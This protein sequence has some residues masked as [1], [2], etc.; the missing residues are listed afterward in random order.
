[1]AKKVLL[2]GADRIWYYMA[3]SLSERGFAIFHYGREFPE[4]LIGVKEIKGKEELWDLLNDEECIALP[5]DDQNGQYIYMESQYMDTLP[6]SDCV[7]DV[8][9]QCKCKC[10]WWYL[11]NDISAI[12]CK[13]RDTF[14]EAAIVEAKLLSGR[15][16]CGSGAVV[17]GFGVLAER[18]AR[19]LK[20]WECRVWVVPDD[21]MER[22]LAGYRQYEICEREQLLSYLDL[23]GSGEEKPDF[24]FQCSTNYRLGARQLCHM[25]Q[26][27]L[28]LNLTGNETMVDEEYARFMKLQ[29]K[30]CRHLLLEYAPAETGERLAQLFVEK[31]G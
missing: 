13:I 7:T 8:L 19:R 6:V 12:L 31:F 18:I 24:V 29:T 9:Y 26:G 20:E 16:I 1:M 10:K 30:L 14:A 5:M 15:T 11:R 2:I 22:R 3:K 23:C 21:E 4:K 25:P 27:M 28:I 17:L